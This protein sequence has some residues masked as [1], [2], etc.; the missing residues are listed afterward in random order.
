MEVDSEAT[1]TF[2][3][4]FFLCAVENKVVIVV[5]VVGA[6]IHTGGAI[7]QA[8]VGL[9][10]RKHSAWQVIKSTNILQGASLRERICRLDAI[11]VRIIFSVCV[12]ERLAPFTSSGVRSVNFVVVGCWNDVGDSSKKWWRTIVILQRFPLLRTCKMQM[13]KERSINVRY[14]E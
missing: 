3:E 4:G 13:N 12:F 5:V 11:M 9:E 1:V 8:F 10:D 7:I 14:Y 6:L 2:F